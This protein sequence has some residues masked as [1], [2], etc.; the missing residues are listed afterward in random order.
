VYFGTSYSLLTFNC[1]CRCRDAWWWGASD[2]CWIWRLLLG[3]CV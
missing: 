1:L 3:N 2:H